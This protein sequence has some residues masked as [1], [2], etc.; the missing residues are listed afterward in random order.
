MKSPLGQT[1]LQVIFGGGIVFA[2]GV[3]LGKIGAGG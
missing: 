2:L 1:V 3:M